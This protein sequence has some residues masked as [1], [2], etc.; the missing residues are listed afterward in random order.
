MCRIFLGYLQYSTRQQLIISYLVQGLAA[1]SDA[2]VEQRP[3]K[4]TDIV[5]QMPR[6]IY[7]GVPC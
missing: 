6:N 3:L 5:Y 7:S 1:Y 2:S 4:A